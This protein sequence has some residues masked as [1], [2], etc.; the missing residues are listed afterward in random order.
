MKSFTYRNAKF[1][2][3]IIIP[4]FYQTNS[5][6]CDPN[7]ISQILLAH[8]TFNSGNFEFLVFHGSTPSFLMIKLYTIHY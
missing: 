4:G 2:C 7:N 1:Q 5:L 8:I 6:P 3:W